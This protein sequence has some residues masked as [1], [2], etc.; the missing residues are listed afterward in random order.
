MVL[1]LELDIRYFENAKELLLFST[2]CHIPTHDLPLP[3]IGV[4]A[5]GL[6]LKL[7]LFGGQFDSKVI[8]SVPCVAILIV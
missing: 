5:P 3:L 8:G 4:L 1:L 2:H 7:S 6:N